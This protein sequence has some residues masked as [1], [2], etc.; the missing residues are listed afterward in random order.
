MQIDGNVVN[1]SPGVA[2]VSTRWIWFNMPGTST[3]TDLG[4]GPR[5]L[6]RGFR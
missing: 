3:E 6:D 1:L 5:K 2:D 4:G